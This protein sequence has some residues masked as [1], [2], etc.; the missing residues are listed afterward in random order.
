MH[1]SS[2][3]RPEVSR[4]GGGETSSLKRLRFERW[5]TGEGEVEG[6]PPVQG[7]PR[8][9]APPRGGVPVDGEAEQTSGESMRTGLLQAGP[10]AAA[11]VLANGAN[12]IVTVAVARVLSPHSYGALNQ[13]TGLFLILSMP[14]TAVVVAVVR[15]VTMWHDSGAGPSG[16]ALGR[17]GPP[18]EFPGRRGL[19]GSGGLG[20]SQLDGRAARAARR[21]G[22]ARPS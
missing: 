9:R 22:R 2:P 8:G 10:L 4:R 1:R 7:R 20:G 3:G 12:V 15:R 6:L 18:A 17:A 5:P 13:L 16:A 21:R 11:G 19:G 14:G